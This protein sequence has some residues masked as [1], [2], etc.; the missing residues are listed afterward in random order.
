MRVVA[1]LVPTVFLIQRIPTSIMQSYVNRGA[2][3]VDIYERA[4]ACGVVQIEQLPEADPVL[5]PSG[6][7]KGIRSQPRWTE[8]DLEGVPP[9]YIKDIGTFVWND[10]FLVPGS[11]QPLAAQRHATSLLLE[12]RSLLAAATRREQRRQ[13]N[14]ERASREAMTRELER[15]PAGD[16]PAPETPAPTASTE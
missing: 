12:R 4:F 16:A 7:V 2:S 10:S 14:A 1:G 13:S 8:Q 3:D 11:E 6:T 15:E 5:K 9:V